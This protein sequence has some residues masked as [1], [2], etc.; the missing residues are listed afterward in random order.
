M[1]HLL[2]PKR[3]FDQFDSLAANRAI[4]HR[5]R[6]LDRADATPHDFGLAETPDEA[7]EE[8]ASSFEDRR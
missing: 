4:L 5:V 3:L 1:F 8:K 2:F 6:K 7:D